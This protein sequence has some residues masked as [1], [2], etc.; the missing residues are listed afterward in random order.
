MMIIMLVDL[1]VRH[2]INSQVLGRR[3]AAVKVSRE[4]AAANRERVI[5]VASRL[6]REKGFDGVSVVDVMKGAGLTH[7]GFYG[8][9]D[10][11]DHL[12]A[13]ACDRA[14]ANAAKK[15]NTIADEAGAE[16]FDTLVRLYLSPERVSAPGSGCIFAALGPEAARQ[17]KPVRRVLAKGLECL[18]DVLNR[19]IPGKLAAERRRRA[20]AAMSEMVGAMVLAR[21]VG[22]R[23]LS[24]EIL[25]AA[26][27]DL[28]SRF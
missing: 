20:I 23:A 26:A 19:T 16:A 2:H 1:N 27:S 28:R 12:A 9:F 14:A 18:L 15:W 7:G 5:D 11:K 24:D 13:E 25:A 10:S 17:G 6:F 4:E 3:T 22:D 21:C 8:Q